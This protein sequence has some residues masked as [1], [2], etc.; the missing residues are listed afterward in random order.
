MT[1]TDELPAS[2]IALL[3]SCVLASGQATA[4][5]SQANEP[6]EEVV[7]T[8]LKRSTLLHERGIDNVADLL[9]ATPGLSLVDHRPGQKRLVIR[10]VQSAGEAG[11]YYDET[12]VAGG[13]P[14]TTNDAIGRVLSSAFGRDVTWSSPPAHRGNQREPELLNALA[15][16]TPY[17]GAHS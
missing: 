3:V 10:G 14:S 6:I 13:A 8:A 7:V 11:L 17:L 1:S 5:E 9:R 2:R 15:D 16:R 4:N 12:P